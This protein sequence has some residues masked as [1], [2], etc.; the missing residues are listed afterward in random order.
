MGDAQTTQT[1][2]LERGLGSLDA[3]MIVVGSMIGSGIFITSAESSRL[4]GSPGWLLAAWALAGVLTITGALSCAELAAMMPRAG[5]QYVFLR[6]AYG[7]AVGFLFGWS[8]LLVIQSGTIAAVAVAFANF[9]GVLAPQISATNYIVAPR[10]VLA[11]YALSLST[12]Q[13]VAVL[14]IL[15][16]TFTNTRGLQIGKWIQ[17][18][19]T[20][21]KTAALA[22]LVVLGL[23]L[24]WNHNSAAYTSSWWNPWANGWTPQGAQSGLTVTG[25][26]ALAMLVGR[27]MVGPLFAQSAWNNVTFTAGEVRDPGRT[28]PRALLAG[29]ATVVGL[30]LLANLAYVVTLPLPAIQN[31]PQN[32]VAT[33]T[34]QAIF[35]A[36]G[37]TLMAIA[38]IISTF[39]CNNGLILAGAR[40]TYA[41][42]RDRLFFARTA[43]LNAQNVP[44]FALVMQGLWA[45]LLT[46]PRTVTQTTDAATGAVSIS[47]GNVYTQLLEYIVSADLV[48]YAL[49]V[50]AVVV[51]RRRLPQAERPYRTHGYPLVPALYVA[52]AALVILDLAYLTPTT[53]GIGYLLVLTG[54]PVY[55][56]WKGK[57]EDGEVKA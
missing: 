38:I 32:R 53:S 57:H 49:M 19:F 50:G 55:F 47:Y 26:L 10:R 6:E 3:T 16:L 39:G 40:V 7:G 35:G 23:A 41:M 48:F 28:L 51:L 21:T 27:A 43:R 12:Q 56:L 25:G 13:L 8:L 22:A 34:M 30:Y 29:C 24:G 15:A 44:A 46:L 9:V 18:S 5:G 11:G 31:A 17:N 42:A 2:R 20:F 52:L 36:P 14:M 54:I 4:V 33:A 45:A 1:P 37:A